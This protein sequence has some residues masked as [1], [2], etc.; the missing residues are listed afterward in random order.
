M[1]KKERQQILTHIIVSCSG[2]TTGNYT[3]ISEKSCVSD[4]LVNL[5]LPTNGTRLERT[6]WKKNAKK[7]AVS[8]LQ[9]TFLLLHNSCIHT[10]LTLS[11]TTTFNTPSSRNPPKP[12]LL[13]LFSFF[14]FFMRIFFVLFL[15]FVFQSFIVG[16][17]SN[18]PSPS[19]S[20]IH[21]FY[22]YFGKKIIES[23]SGTS[24]GRVQKGGNIYLFV[25]CL[26]FVTQNWIGTVVNNSKTSKV[27]VRGG[28]HC[29]VTACATINFLK[30]AHSKGRR[31]WR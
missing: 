28:M 5:L 16:H 11:F 8:E 19:T 20:C 30:F 14:L 25:L 13:P 22:I 24:K 6:T 17:M 9:W 1:L 21:T 26:L 7:F 12:I 29:L 4:M 31:P 3:A 27:H 2:N 23:A 15:S 18:A 10:T